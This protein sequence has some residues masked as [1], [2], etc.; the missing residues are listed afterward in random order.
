MRR[1]VAIRGRT[2]LGVRATR[3]YVQ[4]MAD[5]P[6]YPS[7]LSDAR[8]RLIEPIL[9]AWRTERRGNGLDFGRPPI[10]DLREILN[11]ILYVDR[12]GIPW[13]YLPHDLPPWATMYGYFAKWEKSR[14]FEQI[15][16][17][18]RR[19]VRERE[20]RN[21]E[22]S[23]GVIDSQ[24]VKTSTNV[25]ATSQGIDP[26]KKIVGRKRSI[27]TDSIG[28]LLAVIVTAASVQDHPLGTR[29]LDHAA[30]AHPTISKVWVDGGF[31]PSTVEHGAELGIDVEIVRRD[32]ETRGFRVLPADG[33]SSGPS[34][35]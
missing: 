27:L 17:M 18:L 28:L 9:T 22:P 4:S 2:S 24:S 6:S 25:P 20:G 5:R 16:G 29:L 21:A 11:A 35:G 23:A 3:Q 31:R 19:Q 30:T 10:H 32:P 7:D 14:I 33:Q 8:W 26:G 15:S 13:R 1:S 34:A 12:T